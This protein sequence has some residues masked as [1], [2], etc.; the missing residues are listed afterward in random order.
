MQAGQF[1]G[2]NEVS[3]SYPGADPEV[4][5]GGGGGPGHRYRVGLVWLCG[6]RSGPNFFRERIMHGV[7][8][9]SGGMLLYRSEST[10]EAVVDHHNHAKCLRTGL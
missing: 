4:E 2:N 1:C 6:A 5:E 8:G 3:E 10:F 7:L 9:R